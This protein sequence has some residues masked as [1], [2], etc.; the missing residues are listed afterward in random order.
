MVLG[1]VTSN[2]NHNNPTCRLCHASS[3]NG[4]WDR[5]PSNPSFVEGLEY[6]DSRESDEAARRRSA[7]FREYCREGF[8]TRLIHV[9]PNKRTITTSGSSTAPIP[10]FKDNQ[11]KRYRSNGDAS[12]QKRGDR[13]KDGLN[14]KG[15]TQSCF[16]VS[17]L[18]SAQPEQVHGIHRSSLCIFFGP[19]SRVG[20][21]FLNKAVVLRT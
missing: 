3:G 9:P 12:R 21:N 4:E 5:E 2:L 7:G 15:K 14:R 10:I 6:P 19:H 18:A 11:Y 13:L 17:H 8:T 16:E 1:D 20:S